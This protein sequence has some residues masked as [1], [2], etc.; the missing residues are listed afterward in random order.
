MKKL[1][2]MFILLT[3][4]FALGACTNATEQEDVTD[5][6]GYARVEVNP[7]IDFIVD[8]D[9]LVSSYDLLNEDAEIVAAEL[10][11]VGI[12]VEDALELFLDEAIE[13]GY[14]DVDEE[15]NITITTNDEEEDEDAD[16]GQPNLR[17]RLSERAKGHLE[18][19]GIGVV[20]Q[21][22]T[23]DE[24]L[25][26]LA[27]DYDIGIGRLFMIQRAVELDEELT[28]EEALELEHSEIMSILRANHQERIEAFRN[29]RREMMEEIRDT[30]R[31]QMRQRHPDRFNGDE[32]DNDD[33]DNDDNTEE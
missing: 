6:Y 10:E 7:K 14:L 21:H 15:N 13:L 9:G 8:E 12:P 18:N 26:E 17:E 4:V 28:F 5:Q 25:L 22:G 31:E 20:V 30:M 33:N 2:G 32:D 29:E 11:L 3:G 23:L 16:N 27:E 19:K 24:E 1:L